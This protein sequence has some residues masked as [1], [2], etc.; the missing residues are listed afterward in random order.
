MRQMGHNQESSE[1]L[2]VCM[3]GQGGEYALTGVKSAMDGSGAKLLFGAE[4]SSPL[5]SIQSFHVQNNSVVLY[6]VCTAIFEE[7]CFYKSAC[8]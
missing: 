3:H 7:V 2:P 5:L 6:V 1:S 4:G 8:L